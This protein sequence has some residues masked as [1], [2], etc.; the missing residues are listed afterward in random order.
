MKALILLITIPLII[1]AICSAGSFNSWTSLHGKQYATAEERQYR[2]GVYSKNLDYIEEHNRKN[3]GFI[4]AMNEFGDLTSEEFGAL[5]LGTPINVSLAPIPGAYEHNPLYAMADT[6]D[7]RTKGA[8][9][10]PKK[11][12]TMWFMLGFLFNWS[13]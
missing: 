1:S 3:L 8:V 13:C 5:Y 12:R 10:A 7:W 4:L 6:V 9:T 2:L 11:S